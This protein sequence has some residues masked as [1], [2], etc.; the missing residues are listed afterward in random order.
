MDK[1]SP[2]HREC[3]EG[4]KNLMISTRLSSLHMS[5][6]PEFEVAEYDVSHDQEENPDNDD[7]PK[8][9]ALSEKFTWENLEGND[10]PSD[11][12]KPLP[13]VNIRNHQ[14]V[15]V[16]YLFNND[17]K[18][19]QGG[20]STMTYMTSLT[21][22]KAIQYDLPGIEDM[23]P[24]IWSPVK[25]AYDKH[26]L[27]GISHW[28]EQHK[29]FYTYAQGLQSRHDVYSIKHILA[30]TKVDIIKK[31]GYR[32][33]QEIVVR[34]TDNELYRFKEGDFSCLRINDI[35]DILLLVVHFRLFN[36]NKNVHK[37][38]GYLQASQ[39]SSTWS[40]K[41]PKE[42]QRHQARYYHIW[43][44]EKRPINLH[45]K[46]LKDSFMSM[47]VGEIEKKRANIMIKAI[48]KQLKERKMMRILEKFVGGW[49]YETGLR[50]LQ[51]MNM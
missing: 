18:Y 33:R 40:R 39:R 48:D 14:K 42:Y 28:R 29:T 51:L 34:R 37:K 46:T 21:K 3:Y 32:Y 19:L 5:E 12:T 15:L 27:W 6:E 22:T 43:H 41:L 47:S 4:L 30:V 36:S 45:I 2:E 50:L 20:I 8:E 23:V 38:S 7:E 44:K 17:L 24:N 35:E 1:A 49:D 9:K 10:Y 16:D 31:H 26:A 11:L 25:V 13:L